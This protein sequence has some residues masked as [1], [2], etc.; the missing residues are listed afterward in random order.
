MGTDD[1]NILRD[2]DYPLGEAIRLHRRDGSTSIGVIC[3]ICGW[4]ELLNQG[5]DVRFGLGV[6][7]GERLQLES[8]NQQAQIGEPGLRGGVRSAR[9]QAFRRAVE[10]LA[11]RAV[12]LG[13]AQFTQQPP[14]L[15]G[16][17]PGPAH[18]TETGGERDAPR[19]RILQYAALEHATLP[20]PVRVKA[21]GAILAERGARLRKAS[22][23]LPAARNP[24]RQ[25][26]SAQFGG[27][28]TR[29]QF[30]GVEQRS[31]AAETARAAEFFG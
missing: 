20:R 23:W 21:A 30:D 25:P 4:F 18:Q 13:V 27:I 14:D 3:A 12:F 31:V 26:E 1:R 19:L 7:P 9:L 11:Q 15:V 6:E 5:S 2:A 28:V 24:D 16:S 29:F 17:P 10:A 22:D 8:V